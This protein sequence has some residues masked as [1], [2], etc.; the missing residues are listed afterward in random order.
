MEIRVAK[1]YNVISLQ[2]FH[3]IWRHKSLN[4]NTRISTNDSKDKENIFLI[5]FKCKEK[6]KHLTTTSTYLEPFLPEVRYKLF[7]AGSVGKKVAP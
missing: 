6:V 3:Y 2:K 1:L 4:Y 7:V 5:K